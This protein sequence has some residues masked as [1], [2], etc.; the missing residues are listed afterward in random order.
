MKKAESANNIASV[1]TVP[2]A[3]VSDAYIPIDRFPAAVANAL[4]MLPSTQF[5][6]AF[7]GVSMYGEPL[8]HYGSWILALACWTVAGTAVSAR[9]FR[10]V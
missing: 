1:L 6:D 10:W 9:F 4:R 5:V 8:T 7:R 2:L 3:F